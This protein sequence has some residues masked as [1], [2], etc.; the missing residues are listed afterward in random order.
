MSEVS[1]AVVENTQVTPE[2]N[3]T[4]DPVFVTPE[5]QATARPRSKMAA[6]RLLI[7][8]GVSPG[9]KIKEE[10][11]RRW[12]I[13]LGNSDVANA[14]QSMSAKNKPKTPK[15]SVAKTVATKEIDKVPS[16][17]RK[18]PYR[19]DPLDPEI[20]LLEMCS[21]IGAARVREMLNEIESR[22]KNILR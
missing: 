9:A 13:E 1:T 16:P 11:L 5:Q 10:A 4:S 18:N 7:Q 19:C 22:A 6:A 21:S 3:G 14:K 8:E 12:G 17:D 2:T 20:V 15:K